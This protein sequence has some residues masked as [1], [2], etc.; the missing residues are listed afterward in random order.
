[1]SSVCRLQL[2]HTLPSIPVKR[3]ASCSSISLVCTCDRDTVW[4][5]KS[6]TVTDYLRHCPARFSLHSHP[7][8]SVKVQYPPTLCIYQ[9]HNGNLHSG[10]QTLAFWFSTLRW[11]RLNTNQRSDLPWSFIKQHPLLGSR[12]ACS[13][14]LPL[15]IR[16][17]LW[18]EG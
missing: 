10:G 7:I 9:S 8:P 18:A 16:R 14:S 5:S 12:V 6:T 1:M 2:H 4:L 13:Q 15:R 17:E 3:L 11:R